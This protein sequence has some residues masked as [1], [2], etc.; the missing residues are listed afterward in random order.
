MRHLAIG[1]RAR[2]EESGIMLGN[3]DNSKQLLKIEKI[4]AMFRFFFTNSFAPRI[5]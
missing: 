3:K 2:D 1:P 4:K 5:R